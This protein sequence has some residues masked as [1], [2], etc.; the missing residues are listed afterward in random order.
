MAENT[1]QIQ[2]KR[3]TDRK[4]V[5]QII[6]NSGKFYRRGHEQVPNWMVTVFF[7]TQ[8][9]F[10]TLMIYFS[11]MVIMNMQEKSDVLSV[12]QY[13]LVIF[14][15]VTAYSLYIVKKLKGSLTSTEFMSLF[16]SKSL[17]SYS[18]CYALL[19]KDGKVIFYNENFAKDY[20]VSDDVE[21]KGYLDVLNKNF[22]TEKYMSKVTDS[23]NIGKENSFSVVSSTNNSQTMRNI[24]IVPLER[25]DGVFVLKVITVKIIKGNRKSPEEQ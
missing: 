6:K 2:P 25:P 20:L 24:K 13:M 21:N 12:I 19:N 10:I 22:F 5:K 23:L 8:I 1:R 14:V 15:I 7:I 17:E 3:F 16:L 11:T 18:S 4:D 9:I